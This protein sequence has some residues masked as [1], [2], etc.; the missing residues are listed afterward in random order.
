MRQTVGAAPTLRRR[1]GAEPP[2]DQK[3]RDGEGGEDRGHDAER[4]R[5]GKAA[6]RARAEPEQHQAGDERGQL[7]SMIVP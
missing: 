5:H 4:Q 1:L 6:D 3:A 7:E 2:D